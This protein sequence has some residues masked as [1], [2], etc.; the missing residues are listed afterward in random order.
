MKRWIATAAVA[1]LV[2]ASGAMPAFAGDEASSV[3]PAMTNAVKHQ[4]M[5]PVL[6]GEVNK[7][8]FVDF[9]GKRIYVCCK[10]CIGEVQKAPA[11]YVKKLESDGVVLDAAP[12]PAKVK[13]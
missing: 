6:G 5:C 7:K 9:E 11:K 2:T 3:V 8:L 10:G 4:T 12:A 13:E 1:M